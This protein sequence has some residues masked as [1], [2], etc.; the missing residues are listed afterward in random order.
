MIRPMNRWRKWLRIVLARAGGLARLGRLLCPSRLQNFHV[1]VP[2]KIY[3]GAQRT[4]NNWKISSNNHGIR[5][6]VNLR[7]LCNP[8]DWYLDQCRTVQRSGVSIRKIWLCRRTNCRRP[9]NCGVWWK[10]SIMPSIRSIFIAGAGRSDGAR[11]RRGQGPDHRCELGRSAGPAELAFRT[12][13]PRPAGL[14]RSVFRSLHRLARRTSQS[15]SK[16]TFRH[17]MLH[18]YHGGW[19]SH[20]VEEFRRLPPREGTTLEQPVAYRVKFRNTGTSAW[21]FTTH[22]RSGVHVAYR[23]QDEQGENSLLKANCACAMPPFPPEPVMRDIGACRPWPQDVTACLW[24]SST[25]IRAGSISWA[26]EPID[27]E[28]EIRE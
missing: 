12:R 4:P 28:L 23:I 17:W 10:S 2:G 18:E 5:T 9:R 21:N 6:V 25:N 15:H 7:S 19:C 14:S 16:E 20:E 1:V 26:R 11:L 24:I 3:R 27:E 13:G 8:S 22:V